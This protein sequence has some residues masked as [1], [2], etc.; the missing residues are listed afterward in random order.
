VPTRRSERALAHAL[1]WGLGL[2]VVTSGLL[3]AGL[4]S[5]ADG[6][7]PVAGVKLALGLAMLAEGL[8][9][10]VN[11]R[12][13]RWLT[14]WRLRQRRGVP[15][16]QRPSLRRR[17]GEPLAVGALQLLG[18]AWLAGGLLVAALALPAVL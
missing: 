11:W 12:G 14:L 13:A 15:E 10:A 9:L 16:P 6:S 18:V 4:L 7:R 17:L 3:V 1:Y 8:V 5:F 2:A